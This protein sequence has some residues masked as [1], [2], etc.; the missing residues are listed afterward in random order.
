M[1]VS[2]TPRRAARLRHFIEEAGFSLRIA[3]PDQV[4]REEETGSGTEAHS[5]STVGGPDVLLGA[6]LTIVDLS[7]GPGQSVPTLAW[8]R[9]RL[10]PGASILAVGRG[11]ERAR[12]GALE[13]GADD[14]LPLPIDLELFVA[15]LRAFARR[16][17]ARVVEELALGNLVLNRLTRTLTVDGVARTLTAR[18][19]T[20]L[21]FLLQHRSRVASR[22]E[23]LQR[24]LHVQFDPGTNVLEVNITR[25]R[26]TLARS[27]A[28]VRILAEREVGYV[29][30]ENPS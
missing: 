29:I 7:H 10:G 18:G 13:A 12:I 4:R 9:A 8:L 5:R 22:E 25:L 30:Q 19:F 28:N 14:H 11:A 1:F 17:R 15:Q 16:A 21:E 24:V 6:D 26:A 3:S 2:D 27:G 20:L 23:L